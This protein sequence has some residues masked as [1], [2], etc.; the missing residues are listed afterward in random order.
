MNRIGKFLA[1]TLQ[2]ATI[3][4]WKE[5]SGVGTASPARATLEH[6]LVPTP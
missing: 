6:A 2:S 4:F 1:T 3:F 5:D